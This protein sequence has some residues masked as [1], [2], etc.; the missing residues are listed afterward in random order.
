MTISST[1]LPEAFAHLRK[2]GKFVLIFDE[3][4]MKT[5]RWKMTGLVAVA[6]ILA[7]IPAA[8]QYRGQNPSH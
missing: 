5:N 6:L 4:D 8:A 3:L 7:A 1:D 2:K